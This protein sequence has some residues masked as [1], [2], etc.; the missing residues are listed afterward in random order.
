[1][2]ED[3]KDSG[4]LPFSGEIVP[5]PEL[6][7][8]PNSLPP[9]AKQ[10]LSNLK[11][12]QSMF[13]EVRENGQILG[14]AKVELPKDKVT[15]PE[16]L[17]RYIDPN[18]RRRGIGQRLRDAVYKWLRE[19]GYE[20]VSSGINGVGK[21]LPSGEILPH[22][23]SSEDGGWK[24]YLSMT[25]SQSGNVGHSIDSI[26]VARGGL[27]DLVFTTNLQVENSVHL[28][29]DPQELAKELEITVLP[30]E[31]KLSDLLQKAEEKTVIVASNKSEYDF[32]DWIKKRT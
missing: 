12:E 32:I 8:D 29:S 14:F 20:K 30:D 17:Y 7:F 26:I 22:L 5:T 9:E 13:F 15:P 18:H 19:Q 25:K 2:I 1:M 31:E 3:Q 24:S 16:F 27:F 4:P 28:P 10:Y 6:T 23:D 11:Y 21:I